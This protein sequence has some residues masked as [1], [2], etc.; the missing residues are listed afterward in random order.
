MRDPDGLKRPIV[1]FAGKVGTTYMRQHLHVFTHHLSV[2]SPGL[3]LCL[4]LHH[5]TLPLLDLWQAFSARLTLCTW[6]QERPRTQSTS[7]Q[8]MEPVSQGVG[9][10]AGF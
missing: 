7:A 6:L 10:P 9:R 2:H 1:L 4:C 5:Q 8:F 3:Q